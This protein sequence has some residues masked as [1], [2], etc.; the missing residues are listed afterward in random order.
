MMVE[1]VVVQGLDYC[2]GP[3]AFQQCSHVVLLL[4][5]SLNKLDYARIT[6]KCFKHTRLD[7]HRYVLFSKTRIPNH[8]TTLRVC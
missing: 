5:I 8:V 7:T 4:S 6:T 3:T 1:F 2:T